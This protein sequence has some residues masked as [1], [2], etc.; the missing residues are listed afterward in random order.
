MNS[1]ITGIKND[2]TN[3][4]SEI[5]GMKNDITNMN[6]EITGMKNDISNINKEITKINYEITRIDEQQ[7]DGFRRLTDGLNFYNEKI[8]RKFTEQEE[9][10]NKLDDKIFTHAIL[11]SRLEK[12]GRT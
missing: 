7:R 2:I 4:N 12:R 6:S 1:E 8:D 10:Y 9:K 5:T 11:I 3:M